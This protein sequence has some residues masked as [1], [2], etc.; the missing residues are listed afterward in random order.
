MT[1]RSGLAIAV[2]AV[3][4]TMV[5]ALT[6]AAEDGKAPEGKAPAVDNSIPDIPITPPKFD[7]PAKPAEKPGDKPADKGSKT[8][9]SAPDDKK[10]DGTGSNYNGGYGEGNN[11]TASSPQR[12]K[13]LKQ[14]EAQ[15]AAMTP[16]G[17][18]KREDSDFYVLGTIEVTKKHVVTVDY[19]IVQG[20]KDAAVKVVDFLLH[21]QTAVHEW[22]PFA[23]VKTMAAAKK[24]LAL[25]KSKS[26]ECR[27]RPFPWA[28]K[29]RSA[30]RRRLRGRHLRPPLVR[31]ARRR[32][33][34]RAQG[35][36]D[37]GRLPVGL[38]LGSSRGREARLAHLLPHA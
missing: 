35:S 9:P 29:G 12:N 28:I 32:P 18:T 16:L 38:R 17:S 6:A 5:A 20:V 1:I 14:I 3:V 34:Q 13:L 11:A 31:Q 25:A 2:S 24:Q 7:E 22:K 10:N 23:R 26:V 36:E 37:S 15:L 19:L 8:P 27:W 4:L 21:D 33:F 30:A